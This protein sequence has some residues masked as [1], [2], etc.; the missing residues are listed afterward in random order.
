MSRHYFLS[1][2]WDNCAN[3]LRAARD[4]SGFGAIIY[5]FAHFWLTLSNPPGP[6]G[7]GCDS[8]RPVSSGCLLSPGR[9]ASTGW[10]LEVERQSR[11]GWD[12]IQVQ[13]Q[14][15]G[16][17]MSGWAMNCEAVASP[18]STEPSDCS[19]LGVDLYL[20]HLKP[21]RK[22]A[23]ISLSLSLSLSTTHSQVCKQSDTLCLAM[24]HWFLV[25]LLLISPSLV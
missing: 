24:F 15:N 14:R 23:V 20:V 21:R 22:M 5:S 4:L 10:K 19:H 12:A 13:S 9:P 6:C 1:L 7:P 11:L 16:V 8:A 18:L 3:T 17:S 25:S 2:C